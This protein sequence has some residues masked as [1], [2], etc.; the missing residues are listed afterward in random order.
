[1]YSKRF[2]ATAVSIFALGV[3]FGINMYDY[4]TFSFRALFVALFAVSTL[5]FVIYVKNNTTILSKRAIAAAF[6]VAA[7]SLGVLRVSLFNLNHSSLQVYDEKSDSAV[8]KVVDV[9]SNY[10]DA[11]VYSSGIGISSSTNVRFYPDSEV[12]DIVIGDRLAV[13]V[14]YSFKDGIK[15][16]VNDYSLVAYGKIVSFE[17][18]SGIFSDIR[19]HVSNASNAIFASFEYAGE[20]SKAVTVGDR[21]GLDNYIFSVYKSAGISHILAISGLHITLICMSVYTFLM[22]SYVKQSIA[23]VVASVLAVIFA[24]LV[25]FTPGAVRSAVMLII[26][27]ISRMFARRSDTITALFYALAVLILINPYSIASAG[28]QLSFLCSLGIVA[29]NQF[30]HKIEIRFNEKLRSTKNKIKRAFYKTEYSII[31]SFFVAIVASIF[32]FPVLFLSFDTVSYVSPITNII[33]VP[34]FSFGLAICL[35]ALLIAPISSILATIIAFPAGMMFDAVTYIARF[36]HDLDIGNIS[37]KIVYMIVP[38]VL[39]LLMIFVLLFLQRKRLMYFNYLTAVFFVSILLSGIIN[40]YS[41]E[42]NYRIE[43]SEALGNYVYAQYE[44]DNTYIDIGGYTGNAD[45]IY[46]NGLS[47]LEHYIVFNYDGFTYKR[48]EYLSG[49]LK[50]HRIY[51]YKPQNTHDLNT[52]YR[53]KELANR[54]NCD[55]IIFDDV[56]LYEIDDSKSISVI[57]NDGLFGWFIVFDVNGREIDVLSKDCHIAVNGEYAVLPN[58]FEGD[59]FDILSENVYASKSYVESNS[60]AEKH[61]NTFNGRIRFEFDDDESDIRVYEP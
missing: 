26:F 44:D 20:I 40:K 1:M 2:V 6:A 45:V 43:Y 29:F 59:L 14:S 22:I 32:S 37:T 41:F 39:S 52:F 16:Y 47:S 30:L 4:D 23:C 11:S 5:V 31:N 58:G 60:G 7:F 18:G 38:F 56:Y 8:F 15:Y 53:I 35:V 24:F 36:V 19:R 57:P 17:N 12:K 54:R 61:A 25:G 34:L 9:T 42:G 33:A 49:S 27:M 13:D 21:S 48:V 55:I 28:L 10:I 46:E 51:L 3:V 50:I